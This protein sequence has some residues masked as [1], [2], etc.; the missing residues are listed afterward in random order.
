MNL[1]IC[2]FWIV[3]G[4]TGGYLLARRDLSSLKKRLRAMIATRQHW[5]DECGWDVPS[6]A[7]LDVIEGVG[8]T[9]E[10]QKNA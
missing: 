10:G 3:T 2:V 7:V 9:P 4:F 6:I 1:L 5:N 8:S